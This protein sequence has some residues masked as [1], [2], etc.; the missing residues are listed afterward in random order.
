M[1]RPRIRAQV[2]TRRHRVAQ[3]RGEALAQPFQRVDT[4]LLA[5]D[6]SV[7][8]F[9]RVFLESETRLEIGNACG[10]VHSQ[11]SMGSAPV[12]INTSGIR[13]HGRRRRTS[14]S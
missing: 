3:P 12:S 13:V 5:I 6:G 8:G 10:I 1:G 7:Q 9:E 2:G 14:S 4:P 11:S